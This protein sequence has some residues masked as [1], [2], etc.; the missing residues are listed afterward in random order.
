[1]KESIVGFCIDESGNPTDICYYTDTSVSSQNNLGDYEEWVMDSASMLGTSFEEL[2][3]TKD[4]CE[5][6]FDAINK[7]L[8]DNYK[9][10]LY[11]FVMLSDNKVLAIVQDRDYAYMLKFPSLEPVGEFPID[12]YLIED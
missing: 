2:T 4:S 3:L 7:V 9:A 8:F 6:Y 12:N 10:S 5:K 1:M 11:G